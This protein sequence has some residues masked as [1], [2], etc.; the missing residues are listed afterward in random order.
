VSAK[1]TIEKTE[2][3]SPGGDVR[4]ML[5]LTIQDGWHIY[6]NEPGSEVVKPTQVEL[7][8]REGFSLARV[9]YPLGEVKALDASG[10]ER[11][12]VYEKK[13]T[14]MLFLRLAP[15]TKP[16]SATVRFKVRFQ[17]CNDRACLAPATLSVPLELTIAAP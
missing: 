6:A 10:S 13:A 16:G 5:T 11:V 3:P 14:F 1:A 7:E 12:A 8:P 4:A 2:K 9:E 17:A 15:G